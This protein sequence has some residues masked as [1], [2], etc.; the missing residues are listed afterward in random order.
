MP[1][2]YRHRGTHTMK[3]LTLATTL[4]LLSPIAAADTILGVYAGAGQWPGACIGHAGDR[5]IDVKSLGMNEED[6]NYFYIALGHPVPILPP[7]KLKKMDI[8]SQ[9][10]AT[11]DHSFTTDGTTFTA[12]TQ[13][14]SD[15]DL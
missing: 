1:F 8:T 10:T 13:A 2:Y 6:N 11:V 14:A 12:G 9:R 5:S 3:K 15:F 4:A 7:I